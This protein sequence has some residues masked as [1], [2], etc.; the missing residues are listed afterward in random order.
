MPSCKR[1]FTSKFCLTFY[2]HYTHSLDLDYK[3]LLLYSWWGERRYKRPIFKRQSW[4]SPIS[5]NS[6]LRLISTVEPNF[7]SIIFFKLNS[8]V[9]NKRF[10][11][12]NNRYPQAYKCK[13]WSTLKLNWQHEMKLEVLNKRGYWSVIRC[14]GIRTM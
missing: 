14:V 3:V 6:V 4:L 2:T 7:E 8:D 10:R 12:I 1:I 5:V 11:K 13:I 9:F